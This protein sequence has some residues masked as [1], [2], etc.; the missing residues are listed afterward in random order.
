MSEQQSE[1]KRQ[2][3]IT[4]VYDNLHEGKLGAHWLWCVIE[5]VASGHSEEDAM[6]EFGYYSRAALSKPSTEQGWTHEINQE[7]E[8]QYLKGFQAGKAFAVSTPGWKLVPIEPQSAMLDRAVAFALNVKLSS[9][10]RWTD[11]MK[12]LWATMLA[13]SPPPPI[14]PRE[15]KL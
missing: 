14:E 5:Q 12:D 7:L 4:K 13:G 9:D 1:Q 10:Y 11:Y 3:A 15:E 2:T 6:R 8:R